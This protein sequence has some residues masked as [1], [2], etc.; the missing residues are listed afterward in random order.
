MDVEN[1]VID[2]IEKYQLLKKSDK[3]VVAL[4]GGKDST[5]IIYIL[6]KLGYD[7]HG[8]MIDLYLGSLPSNKR[9]ETYKDN[10]IRTPKGI[11]NKDLKFK[12]EVEKSTVYVNFS[13]NY[14]YT[15]LQVNFYVCSY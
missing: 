9:E 4:S 15:F 13:G 8:L 2:A 10:K 11:V 3:V 7:V 1:Q 5:S 14:E 6:K 12:L